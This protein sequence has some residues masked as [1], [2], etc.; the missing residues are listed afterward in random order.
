MNFKLLS[1]SKNSKDLNIGDFVQAL[2][3]SIHIT[4]YSQISGF[5]DR[6]SLFEER[7]KTSMILNGW[8]M[9]NPANW[10]P[11]EA[12][13]PLFVAFHLNI[14]AAEKMLDKDGVEYLKCHQPIG[15]RDT[16]TVDLLKKHGIDAYFSGCLTLTLGEQYASD[17]VKSKLFF[18]DPE[19]NKPRSK[20]TYLATIPWILRHIRK[21]FAINAKRNPQTFTKD[22]FI[23]SIWFAKTYSQCFSWNALLKAEY[24]THYYPHSQFPTE[25]LALQQAR[26]LIEEYAA[27]ELVV[28]SRIHCALPCLGLGTKVIFIDDAA[29]DEVSTCRFGGLKELFTIGRLKNGIL[30]MPDDFDENDYSSIVNKKDWQPLAKHLSQRC[31]RFVV[32]A[33]KDPI[34]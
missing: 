32:D 23:E 30:E 12:I 28:T 25:T 26:N 21:I 27:A 16:F 33:L 10:P 14:S 4:P 15:C 1:V 29:Q 18:V 7:E 8:Y 31:K 9:A 22:G 20:S 3:A 19:V 34:Q 17:K 5:V 6:E 11:S 2:A 13:N 24:R